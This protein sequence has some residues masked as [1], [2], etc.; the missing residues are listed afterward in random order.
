MHGEADDDEGHDGDEGKGDDPGHD[1]RS[2]F[3]LSWSRLPRPCPAPGA[4]SGRG[5]RPD[6]LT[7]VATTEATVPDAAMTTP[8]H[9][10]LD[11]RQPLPLR[12]NCQRHRC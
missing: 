7:S 8:V 9:Q 10:Q 4:G 2:P 12:R 5:D 3:K 6:L 1:D 11:E